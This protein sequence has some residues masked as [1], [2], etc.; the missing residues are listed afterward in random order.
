[1]TEDEKKAFQTKMKDNLVSSIYGFK[2]SDIT[3]K[4]TSM[5]NSNDTINDI[6]SKLTSGESLTSDDIDS[7]AESE[8]SSLLANDEFIK[9]L[10]SDNGKGVAAAMLKDLMGSTTESYQKTLSS[11]LETA[12]MDLESQ[13]EKLA[14]MTAGTDEYEEQEALIQQ[15]IIAINKYKQQI[16]TL[17][18]EYD[19]ATELENK[20]TE[21]TNKAAAAQ[22]EFEDQTYK[23]AEA[24]DEYNNY[25]E[26][27]KKIVNDQLD[28]SWTEGIGSLLDGV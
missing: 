16:K 4:V 9:A 18:L 3:D 10:N 11:A 1:M 19:L 21:A 6:I 27:S 22:S 8:Y 28:N 20:Y 17:D 14:T 25:L 24:F 12:E 5:Q 7:I 26:Q 15:S 2:V 13:K 23:T